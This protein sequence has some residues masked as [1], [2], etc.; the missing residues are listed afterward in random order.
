MLALFD[1][2][3]RYCPQC[4]QVT[5]PVQD[6]AVLADYSSF[7]ACYCPNCELLYQKANTNALLK[8]SQMS[9]GDLHRDF[10]M[11][12]E[13]LAAAALTEDNGPQNDPESIGSQETEAPQLMVP[14]E[15]IPAGTVA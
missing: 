9:G 13:R 15:D 4:G 2:V 6:P 1:F 3:P 10:R 11:R 8:A 5:L 14:A 7:F 12:L